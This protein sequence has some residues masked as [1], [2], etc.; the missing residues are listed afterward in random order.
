MRRYVIFWRNDMNTFDLG[1]ILEEVHWDDYAEFDKPQHH[2][3]SLQH[4][5]RM[6]RIF[7]HAVEKQADPIQHK[8]M[9]LSPRMV[10]ILLV[11]IFTAIITAATIIVWYGNIY[12]QRHS[13]NIELFAD[14]EGAPEV[15]EEVYELTEIPEGYVLIERYGEKG[16]NLI[17]WRYVNKNS[18]ESIIFVQ[19]T[20]KDFTHHSD[21]EKANMEEIEINGNKALIFQSMPDENEWS[22]IYY[23]I[24]NYILTISTNM[25]LQNT[26][27]MLKSAKIKKDEF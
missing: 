9:K 6:R 23:D 13:D 27:N 11:L 24:K 20:R 15:I 10:L 22:Y 8:R 1:R 2:I 5:L 25:S 17:S 26:E 18:N 21:I 12:G 3:K 7:N 4:R 14:V 16:D 19:S